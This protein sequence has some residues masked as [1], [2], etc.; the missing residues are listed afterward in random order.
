MMPHSELACLTRKGKKTHP[1]IVRG[2]DSERYLKCRRNYFTSSM[3]IERTSFRL[4]N[5]DTPA[6]RISSPGNRH[7]VL[8]MHGYGGNKEEQLGL[9]FRIAE[10]GFDTYAIDLRGHGENPAPLD[11][12]ILDDVN[13]IVELLAGSSDKVVSIGHSLGGRIALLS[14]AQFRV[15]ISPSVSRVY[16]E[17]T[18]QAIKN[19]RQ[20]RVKET[21]PDVNFEIL[22]Q[23]PT[24]DES[25]TR[26][27]L[28]IY[29]SRD[30]HDVQEA[31]ARLA[32]AFPWNVKLIP[33]ALHSDIFLLEETFGE[34]ER[35]LGAVAG[36]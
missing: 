1:E 24:I 34:M 19:F 36:K 28:I 18:K 12:A 22:H 7:N 17:Q 5:S 2:I 4:S 33:N 31:C 25:F 6:I 3:Q 15:G 26:D 11:I 29:G 27:D 30:V 20:F 10:Y 8:V 13:A 21:T 32:T 16:S 35:Y 23:L 14:K 9:C